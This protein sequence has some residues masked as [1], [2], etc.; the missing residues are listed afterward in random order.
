MLRSER[1]S[2]ACE[3][4]AAAGKGEI[5]EMRSRRLFCYLL[6]Q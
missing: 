3:S 2:Y 6:G 4:F 1:R 5:C